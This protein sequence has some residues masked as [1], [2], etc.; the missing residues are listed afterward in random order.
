MGELREG[1]GGGR[2]CSFS[3]GWRRT[4]ED[5]VGYLTGLKHV[6][7]IDLL[8]NK[9]VVLSMQLKYRIKRKIKI[10]AWG[11]VVVRCT[12]LEERW[13]V[14]HPDLENDLLS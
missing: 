14:S 4:D 2:R 10:L 9:L 13:Q 3:R 1:G 5:S 11:D 7:N 6:T 12:A 8:N